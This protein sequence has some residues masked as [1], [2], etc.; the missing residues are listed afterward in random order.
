MI[1][2]GQF[3]IK[4][5]SKVYYVIKFLQSNIRPTMIHMVLIISYMPS[6]SRDV[7]SVSTSRSRDIVSKCHGLVKTWEG[8]GLDLVS[9]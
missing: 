2:E 7:V 6:I 9:D 3:I 4:V 8:L 5:N 1:F